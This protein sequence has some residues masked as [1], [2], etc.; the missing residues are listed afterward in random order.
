MGEF[1]EVDSGNGVIKPRVFTQEFLES[2][3]RKFVD[4]QELTKDKRVAFVGI[5]D[6]KGV[7][8]IASLRLNW[9]DDKLFLRIDSMIEHEWTGDNKIGA[10]LLF[11]VK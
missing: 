3:V 6:E 5:V 9:K 2:S 4:N 7:K 11:S 8:G 10:Q 1:I